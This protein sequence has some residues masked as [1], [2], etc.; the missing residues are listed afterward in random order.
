M[1]P[2]YKKYRGGIISHQ[3]LGLYSGDIPVNLP[4]HE[5]AAFL[6]WNGAPIDRDT[7][8]IALAFLKWTYDE[9]KV[10][11]QA[12]FF[13]NEEK[14]L[15]RP[16]VLPQYIWSAGHTREIEEDSPT[17][18][19]TLKKLAMDGF[20]EAGT[21]HHHSLGGAFASGGDKGDEATRSGFHVTVGHMTSS[22]ADIHCRA[23]FRGME[24]TQGTGLNTMHWLPGIRPPQIRGRSCAINHEI[25]DYWLDLEDLPEFPVAWKECM[26][27]R[28]VTG[29]TYYQTRG[30]RQTASATGPTNGVA[31]K[32]ESASER[33]DRIH[34][35]HPPI[36]K[37]ASIT[38]WR[39]GPNLVKEACWTL[40]L[41]DGKLAPKKIVTMHDTE[42]GATTPAKQLPVSTTEGAPLF[43]A[44]ELLALREMTDEEF[45]QTLLDL[46]QE[47]RIERPCY[48]ARMA[49]QF[50]TSLA[51][52]RVTCIGDD[53]LVA[54]LEEIFQSLELLTRTTMRSFVL[55]IPK[56]GAVDMGTMPSATETILF[57]AQWL[58]DLGRIIQG[59]A[60]DPEAFQA[61]VT[62]F[63]TGA[64][65]SGAANAFYGYMCDGLRDGIN[66]GQI[67]DLYDLDGEVT[68][69]AQAASRHREHSR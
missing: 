32:Y 8:R 57:Q 34:K 38:L 47:K 62:S 13:Y 49:K 2:Q 58:Q 10:E 40:T 36:A 7:F 24:Y 56:Q 48:K 25:R 66:S 3:D 22:F 4:V 26:V 33:A 45:N 64:C 12:R 35:G 1:K 5:G 67:P 41:R 19:A 9:H 46:A 23:T 60:E 29:T 54:D 51:D 39:A 69:P 6:N 20:Q 37:N 52:L 50:E 42:K 14:G 53:P 16:V 65:R 30:Y 63:L 61:A 43:T 17:K 28:E 59:L 27:E 55:H 68:W 44:D 31:T 18:E 15:W 21:I 11:G